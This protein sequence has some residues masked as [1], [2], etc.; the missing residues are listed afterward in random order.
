MLKNI[1]Y[2]S[3]ALLLFTQ[4]MI[5]LHNSNSVKSDYDRICHSIYDEKVWID[6]CYFP[7]NA[8]IKTFELVRNIELGA[9]VIS[10]VLLFD[11]KKFHIKN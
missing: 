7:Y 5:F 9:I 6:T 1:L 11:F 4:G 3:V 2:T 10:A 8:E